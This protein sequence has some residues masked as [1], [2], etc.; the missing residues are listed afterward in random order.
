MLKKMF[1]SNKKKRRRIDTY[2]GILKAKVSADTR[3]TIIVEAKQ[4]KDRNN[5]AE[6]AR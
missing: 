5:I 6:V 3:P 2:V 1:S 4:S